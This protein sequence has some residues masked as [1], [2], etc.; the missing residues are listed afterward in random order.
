MKSRL[1]LFLVIWAISLIFCIFGRHELRRN[2]C[3]WYFIGLSIGHLLIL[4]S[5]CLARIVTTSTGNNVFQYIMSLCK[6]RTYA[7]YLSLYL[8]RYFLCLISID[9]WMVTSS[10][11]SASTEELKSCSSMVNYRWYN[12]LD[13]IQFA[14]SHWISN[15][16]S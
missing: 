10:S 7:F 2:V 4:D 3:S 13:N 16:S 5:L 11:A 1:F 14:C 12:L 6:L 15:R 8:S 9:R